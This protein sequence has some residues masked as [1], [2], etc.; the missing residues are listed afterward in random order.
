MRKPLIRPWTDTERDI[1]RRMA[2]NGQSRVAMAARLNR[3]LKAI[4]R[5]AGILGLDLKRPRPAIKSEDPDSRIG[6]RPG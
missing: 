6:A 1:L 5:E 3:N 4:G 2:E